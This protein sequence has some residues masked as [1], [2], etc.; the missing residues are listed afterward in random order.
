MIDISIIIVSYNT[1]EFV[2]KCLQSIA[3]T[4]TKELYYEV[5]VVDNNSSDNT[6]AAVQ[7]SEFIQ[8]PMDQYLKII[9][10]KK[11][12]GYSKGNN[13][14][15]KKAKGKYLLFLNPDTV[16]YPETIETM[17]EFMDRY[18]DAGCATCRVDLP[19][20][21]LDDACHR[22][23]PTPWNAFCYFSGLSKVFSHSR[24]FSGYTL[25]WMDFQKVHEID[26]CAGAFMIIRR[27]AGEQIGWW[28]ED[29]FWYGEDLDFC[30]RLKKAKWK[31]Y[32]V[33]EVSILHY[34][35]VSGG[36]KNDSKHL[37]LAD[38]ETKRRAT[39]ARFDAMK[40]FYEKHYKNKYPWFI[41]WL[42]MLAIRIKL[43]FSEKAL[44]I[45]SSKPIKT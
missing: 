37:T 10:N 38:E 43:G 11:N 4:F 13:I 35:G 8:R 45:S 22:G 31:I 29:F 33:P 2:K 24:L 15:I 6:I 30:Y 9:E 42:V 17:I 12:V 40:V 20:G 34:K 21:K 7:N 36:I 3:R 26:S 14:G 27:E 25:G 18:P 5:I 23:F 1:K 41:S 39:R 32:F 16:V 28:D 19:N 44:E